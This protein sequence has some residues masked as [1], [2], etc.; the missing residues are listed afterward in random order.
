MGSSDPT[1]KIFCFQLYLQESKPRV[2][3][4]IESRKNAA[5][6][7]D[8]YHGL[9]PKQTMHFGSFPVLFVDIHTDH[10]MYLTVDNLSLTKG[11]CF[12][13]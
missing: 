1:F 10:L 12:L 5:I 13:N 11:Y 3:G 8:G 9:Y 6:M 7:K 2:V 4:E